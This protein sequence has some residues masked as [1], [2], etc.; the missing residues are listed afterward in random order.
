MTENSDNQRL[1]EI[2]KEDIGIFREWIKEYS[3]PLSTDKSDLFNFNLF[4]ELTKKYC[5]ENKTKTVYRHT[6]IIH[7]DKESKIVPINIIPV[8]EERLDL[9]KKVVLKD[10]DEKA[11]SIPSNMCIHHPDFCN[12]EDLYYR[13]F[14]ALCSETS[15]QSSEVDFIFHD[16]I[17]QWN[18]AFESQIISISLL[19]PLDSISVKGKD[20]LVMDDKFQIKNESFRIRE[21][22]ENRID[23]MYFNTIL[24]YKT[25][26]SA[27]SFPSNTSFDSNNYEVEYQKF[28]MEYQDKLKELHLFVN[29]IYLNGFE[30]KWRSPIIKLPWWFDLELFV[31][32]KLQ[33][34]KRV[35]I[36]MERDANNE[37][38]S[39]FSE[40]KRSALIDKD[41]VILNSY[42]RLFQHDAINE[43]F[44]IDAFTFFEAMFAKGSNLYVA[45]RL[46]L[47]AG[48]ILAK[49]MEEFWD[50]KKFM[51]KVYRIR[52][53]AVHGSNWLKKLK[54]FLSN[55]SENSTEDNRSAAE[56]RNKIISYMN[57]SL[58]YLIERMVQNSNILKEM[59]ND[60]LYFFN[61]GIISTE[62][63]N[64]KEILDK[65]KQDYKNQKYK[66][67]N[68]WEEF[69]SIF[70]LESE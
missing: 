37:I 45:A 2:L 58:R 7:P 31:F 63:N 21:K 20:P 46:G 12:T 38:S 24:M 56:F 18:R 47:N 55:D 3:I 23:W 54:E 10:F 11:M 5:F 6:A 33:R 35:K 66:Y 50:I 48:A 42:Y 22:R 17:D 19:I 25:E 51:Q 43:Y 1:L 15:W 4:V 39:V 52:S 13:F 44:I 49:D 68:R 9:F 26:I 62:E 34:R 69:R 16:L 65:I 61:N 57:S 27:K 32:D 67:E 41:G 14:Y 53:T 60:G 29:A 64:R 8:P 28:E 40:L 30:F 70:N 59:S 36:F